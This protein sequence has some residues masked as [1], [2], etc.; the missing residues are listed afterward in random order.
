MRLPAWRAIVNAIRFHSWALTEELAPT[1]L[2]VGV[3]AEE[4]NKFVSLSLN[5][6]DPLAPATQTTAA[7][8]TPRCLRQYP[9][10][11]RRI[12][13]IAPEQA[14]LTGGVMKASGRKGS[15]RSKITMSQP[16]AHVFLRIFRSVIAA[17]EE[18]KYRRFGPMV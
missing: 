9:D 11:L 15:A 14:W 13:A 16:S 18:A 17:R 4:T 2:R 5:S 10:M 3:V 7:S 12:S 8:L 6:L 1:H